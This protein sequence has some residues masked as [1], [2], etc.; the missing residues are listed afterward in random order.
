MTS[1][2]RSAWTT[3]LSLKKTQPTKRSFLFEP[4]LSLHS[5]SKVLDELWKEMLTGRGIE[6]PR[7]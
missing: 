4:S 5:I 7:L 6:D 1:S 2:L 3:T